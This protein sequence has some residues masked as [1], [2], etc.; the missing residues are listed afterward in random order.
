MKG[1]Y[2]ALHLLKLKHQPPALNDGQTHVQAGA[3]C[4]LELTPDE[5][6]LL[7]AHHRIVRVTEAEYQTW[8]QARQPAPE[9]A[10]TFTHSPA[11]AA[12]V[13]GAAVPEP[14]PPPAAKKPRGKSHTET[15]TSQE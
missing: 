4:V 3:C 11:T 2:R 12:V 6:E 14:P 13:S 8:K 5:A 15:P 10:P 1:Y 9:E 7:I